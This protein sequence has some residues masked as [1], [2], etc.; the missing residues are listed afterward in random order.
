M[1]TMIY[2]VP[3]FHIP[4]EALKSDEL[5]HLIH[6]DLKQTN[7]KPKTKLVTFGFKLILKKETYLQRKLLQT[8]NLK[9]D[10]RFSENLS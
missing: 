2:T 3:V 7:K 10:Y 1:T 6:S 5:L 4:S 8:W 9:S